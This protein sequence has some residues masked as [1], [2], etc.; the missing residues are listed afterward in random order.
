MMTYSILFQKKRKENWNTDRSI[1]FNENALVSKQF[2][3]MQILN[4]QLFLRLLLM[5]LSCHS[6]FWSIHL[7]KTI[8]LNGLYFWWKHILRSKN[9]RS[10]FGYKTIDST[11]ISAFCFVFILTFMNNC[12]VFF[13]LSYAFFYY[14]KIHII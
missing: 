11:I 4:V 12:L 2:F 7:K 10:L 8:N 5:E 3:Y 1:E 6:S 9:V 13:S 14:F